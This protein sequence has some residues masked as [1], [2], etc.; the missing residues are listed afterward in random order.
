MRYLIFAF[1][2]CAGAVS[3][4]ADHVDKRTVQRAN[5]SV[6]QLRSTNSLSRNAASGTGEGSS[7]MASQAFGGSSSGG[8]P[9]APV[10][11]QHPGPSTS[12]SPPVSQPNLGGPIQSADPGGS[13]D[14]TT[15]AP[16]AQGKDSTP[17][18]NLVIAAVGLLLA[19]AVLLFIVGRLADEAKKLCATPA[20]AAEGAAMYGTAQWLAGIAAAMGATAVVLGAIIMGMGQTFQGLMFVAGG[21]LTTAL[22]VKALMEAHDAKAETEAKMA[23]SGDKAE[24]ALKSEEASQAPA[25]APK[26]EPQPQA[27]APKPATQQGQATS[28]DAWKSG[29][30]KNRYANMI[31]AQN[32]PAPIAGPP[33]TP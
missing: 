25:E 3:S 30:F 5:R 13:N 14:G 10:G 17:W 20:T 8:M 6:S 18:K 28:A 27:E 2:Y 31:W 23:E 22:A 12:P 11:T 26:T 9:H 24:T 33:V 4:Y 32:H 19:A 29:P 15:A 21:G 7:A 16:E 1:L